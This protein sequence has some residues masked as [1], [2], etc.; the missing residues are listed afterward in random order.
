MNRCTMASQSKHKLRC[1]D[2]NNAE[3]AILAKFARTERAMYCCQK[4]HT[5]DNVSQIM[6]H[7][8]VMLSQK[9]TDVSGS[10]A[11]GRQPTGSKK[12]KRALNLVKQKALEI[13]H[14]R[15]SVAATTGFDLTLISDCSSCFNRVFFV[16]QRQSGPTLR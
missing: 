4:R 5:G 7:G 13:L 16:L 14:Q 15:K 6:L 3:P 2:L 10:D 1:G 12:A 8:D 9:N 11:C